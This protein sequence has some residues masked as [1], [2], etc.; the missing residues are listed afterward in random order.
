VSGPTA[1][2]GSSSVGDTDG[3]G[4]DTSQLATSGGP[5]VPAIVRSGGGPVDLV[6]GIVRTVAEQIGPTVKPA[7]VAAV[8]TTFGFPL[9]LMLAVLLF[10]IVQWRFDD[11]DPKLRSAPLTEADTLLPYADE[12]R[13]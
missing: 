9:A 2:G 6:G 5:L 1:A 10:L 13:R 12:D 4:T 3:P 7:A 11:R 8:A